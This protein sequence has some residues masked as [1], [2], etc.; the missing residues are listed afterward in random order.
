[1]ANIIEM[2]HLDVYIQKQQDIDSSYI[3]MWRTMNRLNIISN[4]QYND[5]ILFLMEYNI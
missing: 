1:M 4:K 2:G 5:M 3:N